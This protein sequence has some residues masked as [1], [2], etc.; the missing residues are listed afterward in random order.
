[1]E[2][3]E[4]HGQ[5]GLLGKRR[6]ALR[7]FGKV[8]YGLQVLLGWTAVFHVGFVCCSSDAAI[9]RTEEGGLKK[10]SFMLASEESR[11]N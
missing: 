3:H 10:V 11:F 1:M 4:R 6:A 2:L 9:G 5:S 7:A 8:N